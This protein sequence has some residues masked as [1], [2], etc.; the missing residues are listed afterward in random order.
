MFGRSLALAVALLVA[1]VAGAQCARSQSGRTEAV[2]LGFDAGNGGARFAGDS[3]LLTTISPN[4]DGFRDRA[5]I[6]FRL[7][8]P[9]LVRLEIARTKPV[10]RTM[11]SETL[12]LPDGPQTLH[13]AP[14][15]TTEPRTYVVRLTVVDRSGY[16]HTYGAARP[17]AGA[18][19]ETPVI[20]VLGVDAAFGRTSYAPGEVARLAIA[21]DAQALTLQVFRAGPERVVTRSNRELNGVPA[22]KPVELDWSGKRSAPH[23]LSM[24]IGEWPSGLYYAKLVAA[25]GRVGYAPFVLRPRHLG[26]SPVAVVLPTNTWQAYNFRDQDGDGY[27]DTWYAGWR[28]RTVRLGRPYLANGVPPHFRSYDLPFLHWLSR[29]GHKVDFLSDADLGRV[30]SGDRLARAYTLV[31]FPGHHE[32]VTSHEYGIVQRYRDL[33][34]NLAF[35]SANNFFWRIVRHGPLLERTAQWRD[36]GHAEAGLI[37]VQYRG[38]DSGERRAPFVVRDT[39]AAPWLFEA[40]GLHDGSRFGNY[41]IEIDATAPASPPGTH[42]LAEIPNLYGPGFSAQMTYY[43]SGSGA[44]VFAAGAFTLAGSAD[45]WPQSRLLD[46]LWAQL[47]RL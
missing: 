10:P 30:A 28:A 7:T 24:P 11:F 25:D 21:T 5:A 37:G 46:N 29:H 31:I 9:A 44:K 41:G 33:G 8:A 27:G 12:R 19:P 42:V 16:R 14:P 1:V 40:T 17:A 6:H 18:R 47:S 20:R 43:E 26:E 38:N 36:L 2:A 3:Q 34:G 13:W 39:A 32:Y 22:G 15:A 4:G 45:R 35:L 23:K